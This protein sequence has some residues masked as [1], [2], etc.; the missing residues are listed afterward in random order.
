MWHQR[1]WLIDHGAALYFHH[2]W[3]PGE[4]I[5]SQ[6]A[7]TLIKNH[8]LLP[9]AGSLAETDREMTSRLSSEALAGILSSIPD[10]WLDTNGAFGAETPPRDVY[11]EYLMQ[12]LETPR[13]FLEE[14]IHARSQNV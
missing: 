8:V 7:F 4:A 9:L 1:L 3:K 11:Y 12:R 2:G 10:A 6:D 14:A 5:R 13:A